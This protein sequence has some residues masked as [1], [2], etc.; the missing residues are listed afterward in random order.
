MNV[1]QGFQFAGIAA[2]IKPH[3]KDLALV[4]SKTPC[5]LAACF[6]QNK[7][8][9]APILDAEPRIP[10][11]DAH[12]VLINSGNANALTGPAGIEAVATIRAALARELGVGAD[13]I[14]TASTG[15]IGV[16][17]PTRASRWRRAPSWSATSPS[18]LPRSARDPA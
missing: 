14:A 18:R 7:A 3:R 11:K 1:P 10:T 4:Y 5:A 2:G 13:A 9:A 16:P 8:K 6:T 15:V 12:A 17:P